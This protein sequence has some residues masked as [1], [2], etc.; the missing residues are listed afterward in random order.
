MIMNLRG[1]MYDAF[2]QIAEANGRVAEITNNYDERIEKE[3]LEV[4]ARN[5][6]QELS[7]LDEITEEQ[8]IKFYEYFLSET[9]ELKEA[10]TW[11][12]G[13]CCDDECEYDDEVECEY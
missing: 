12:S 5:M 6:M 4:S 13:C 2:K 7:E 8:A 10:F 9:E 11:D 1:I 3:A